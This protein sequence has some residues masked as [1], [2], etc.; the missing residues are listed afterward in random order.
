MSLINKNFSSYASSGFS[1]NLATKVRFDIYYCEVDFFGSTIAFGNF[2][3]AGVRSDP[4]IFLISILHSRVIYSSQFC[5]PI[6]YNI[7][8]H[9]SYFM[10]EPADQLS[11]RKLTRYQTRR[12]CFD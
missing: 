2:D 3:A 4:V 12:L 8:T 6:C 7:K 11:F 10:A 1:Q 5:Y 9:I